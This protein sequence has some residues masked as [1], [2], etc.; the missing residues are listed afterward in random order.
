VAGP[1]ALDTAV[2]PTAAQKKQLTDGVAG[3]ADVLLVPNLDAGNIL[4]KGLVYLAQAEAAG[5]LVGV[6]CPIVFS[7]RSASATE[8]MQTL[9]LTCLY[10][11]RINM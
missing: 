8:R 9:L 4:S 7:S 6:K 3:R 11:K 2:S 10:W 5:L 1:L